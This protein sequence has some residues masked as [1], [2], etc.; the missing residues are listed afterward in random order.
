MAKKKPVDPNWD[1]ERC[2]KIRWRL[3]ELEEDWLVRK[4]AY[5]IEKRRKDALKPKKKADLEPFLRLEPATINTAV[6]V[7]SLTRFDI[8]FYGGSYTVNEGLRQ[9]HPRGLRRTA[10]LSPAAADGLGI[11]RSQMRAWVDDTMDL[12]Q[13][14]ALCNLQCDCCPRAAVLSCAAQNVSAAETDGF[15]VD[16]VSPPLLTQ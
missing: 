14:E 7:F 3:N 6:S 11:L 10:T 9:L 12:K 16:A 13:S 8:E 2:G 15:R 1:G 4:K 5:L